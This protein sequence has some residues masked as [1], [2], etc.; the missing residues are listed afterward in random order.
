MLAGQIGKLRFLLSKVSPFD[1]HGGCTLAGEFEGEA[2]YNP[3]IQLHLIILN[4]NEMRSS[5]KSA[6]SQSP[7]PLIDFC[8]YTVSPSRLYSIIELPPTYWV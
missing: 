8:L 1:W 3:C 2:P 7:Q 5:Y 4:L 6:T